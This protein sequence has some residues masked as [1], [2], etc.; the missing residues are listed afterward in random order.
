VIE[1]TY[2][3]LSVQNGTSYLP[4]NWR[5]YA[6]TGDQEYSGTDYKVLEYELDPETGEARIVKELAE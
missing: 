5:T 1:E 6:L 3:D 4:S 2:S